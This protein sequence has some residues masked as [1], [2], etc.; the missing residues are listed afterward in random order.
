[1]PILLGPAQLQIIELDR[2]INDE[3]V[4]DSQ[5]FHAAEG[6]AHFKQKS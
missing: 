3:Q 5:P 1:L 4:A 2:S 6:E